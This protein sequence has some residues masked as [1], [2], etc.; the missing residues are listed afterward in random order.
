[1]WEKFLVPST[2]MKVAVMIAVAT[3]RKRVKAMMMAVAATKSTRSNSR[4]FWDVAVDPE[5]G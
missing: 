1:M 2:M 3:R 4:D 5:S